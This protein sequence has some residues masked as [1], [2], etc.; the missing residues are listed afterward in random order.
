M[1]T[2]AIEI[3]SSGAVVV[4]TGDI[5]EGGADNPSRAVRYDAGSK[6]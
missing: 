5:S 2:M 4:Q 3:G 1:D 6:S